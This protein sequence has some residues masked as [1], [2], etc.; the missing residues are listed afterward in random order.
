MSYPFPGMNP[1]L[2]LRQRWED[3]HNTLI[4]YIREALSPRVS[5]KYYIAV[6]ARVYRVEGGG[7]EFV[8]RPDHTILDPEPPTG[9]SDGVRTRR[10]PVRVH[11]PITDEVHETY[12]EVRGVESGD[13]VTVLEV[14][15]YDN[16]RPGR[17]RDSYEEKRT[18]ILD[19][20][21]H[22]VE[23]DLLRDE[24]PML[25]YGTRQ[26]GDYRLLVSAASK[27]PVADLYPFDVRDPIPPIRIPLKKGDVEPELDLG[28][29]LHDMYD[30]AGYERR[31]DYRKDPVPPLRA[32]DL[33]WAREVLSDPHRR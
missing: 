23:I 18:N 12:L 19:S 25:V 31:V 6:E 17:G 10:L 33:A 32:E 16:K 21:A 24:P 11:V 1:W 29:V 30:R 4:I 7:V 14:L 27:R 9:V 28:K 20:R 13:V 22:L 8:G 3:V 5:P 15:S 2:E 26:M